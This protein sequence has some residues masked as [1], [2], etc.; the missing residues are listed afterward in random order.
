[1]FK[2]K[3]SFEFNID[4]AIK[5]DDELNVDILEINDDCFNE[6]FNTEEKIKEFQ[7]WYNVGLSE[8]EKLSILDIIYD[9]D[10]EKTG[11]LTVSLKSKLE[12]EHDF[13]T[14]LVYYLFEDC[15][16]KIY[17]HVYGKTWKD[18]WD[19]RTNSHVQRTINVDYDD[20]AS[21]TSYSN[22]NIVNI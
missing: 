9:R 3:I 6:V 22:I 19:Y 15:T 20:S 16:P 4:D 11:L 17:Y 14:E 18:D 2:Y 7:N 21:I 10:G 13:A 8:N 1:M 5:Y 12:N